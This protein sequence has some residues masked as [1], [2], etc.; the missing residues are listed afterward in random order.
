MCLRAKS[1]GYYEIIV[2]SYIG[3]K[4]ARD[5]L[6]MDLRYLEGGKTMLYGTLTDQA[7]L[8]SVIS[9]IRD[10]NLT[11]VSIIWDDTRAANR[12]ESFVDSLQNETETGKEK[13]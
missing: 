8:F 5:F 2:S 4:R 1:M 6:G 7:A 10:M 13:Q 3:G 12:H 9:K 11:L